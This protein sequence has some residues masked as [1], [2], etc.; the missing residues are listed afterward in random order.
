MPLIIR[1]DGKA[2]H[3]LTKKMHRPFDSVLMS[4]MQE[5]MRTLCEN[6]QGCQ[7]GYTQSDE[8]SLLLTDYENLDT[9]AWFDKNLQKIVS[10]SASIATMT[11][12]QYMNQFCLKGIF[13]SENMA[14][15]AV[16]RKTAGTAMFDS[17]AFV[18]P[19]EE[20]CNYFLWRQQDATKNAIQMVG[21][22][23]F[24]HKSLNSLNGSQIQEKLFQEKGINF[25]NLPAE[26]KRG[27]CAV[28]EMYD[29]E[30]TERSRWVIDKEIPIFSQNREYIEQYM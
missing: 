3:S 23:H 22:A 12:N 20:V 26:Q 29:K 24:S 4:A 13:D 11:F 7:V 27:S 16:Y 5:T 28:K 15:A 18:I 25:N 2:F 17:R 1:I 30:G 14:D 6:I 10:V 8:I 19:K 21:R 9:D